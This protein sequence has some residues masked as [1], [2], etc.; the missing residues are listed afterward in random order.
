ML[1]FV[2]DTFNSLSLFQFVFSKTLH[3]N[4]FNGATIQCISMSRSFQNPT[5]FMVKLSYLQIINCPSPP[6]SKIWKQ[7]LTHIK[8]HWYLRNCNVSQYER[9]VLICLL[10]QQEMKRRE[11]LSYGQ[12]SAGWC[13]RIWV[14]QEWS[15]NLYKGKHLE[16]A[17]QLYSIREELKLPCKDLTSRENKHIFLKTFI[18]I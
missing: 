9:K 2:S 15:I 17:N 6:A 1:H 3:H 11:C 5:A 14:L 16:A 8:A 7:N 18:G 4:W 10:H 12:K 13:L